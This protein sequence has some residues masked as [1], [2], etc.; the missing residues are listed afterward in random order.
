MCTVTVLALPSNPQ[1]H[2][3]D[4]M[5]LRVVCNRDELR[6]R[7]AALPPVLRSFGVRQA[8][9]PIDATAGGTWIAANDAGLILAL[10]NVN[11][12]PAM[13]KGAVRL[14]RSTIIP[15]LLHCA[16]LAGALHASA[17]IQASQFPPFR[18]VLIDQNAAASVIGDGCRLTVEK[19]VGI[20]APLLFTSSGLGDR[21]IEPPRRELFE[22][23]FSCESEWLSSQQ[24]FHAHTWEKHPELS[25]CMSRADARTVSRTCVE[26]NADRARVSYEPLDDADTRAIHWLDLKLRG[27]GI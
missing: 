3:A 2:A 9:L 13:A 19:P 1:D 18:L 6:T 21:L 7:A 22:Q 16:T 23:L 12:Q 24:R 4:G 25:V 10:L 14:S 8:I 15:S 11:A 26:L 5:R 27:G 17:R 20:R